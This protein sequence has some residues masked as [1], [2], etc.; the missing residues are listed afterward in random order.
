MNRRDFHK[1]DFVFVKPHDNRD[2]V[3]C[4][5]PPARRRRLGGEIYKF[6]HFINSDTAFVSRPVS[7]S[8]CV[9]RWEE[10]HGRKFGSRH[11]DFND[12]IL[13]PK[14]TLKILY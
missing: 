3:I 12:R 11:H 7:F 6:V 2:D 13:V 8:E 4:G 10:K 9:G 14:D 5:V 1:G